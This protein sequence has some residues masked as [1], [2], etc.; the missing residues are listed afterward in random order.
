MILLM[1]TTEFYTLDANTYERMLAINAGTYGFVNVYYPNQSIPITPSEVPLLSR[2]PCCNKVL[3]DRCLPIVAVNNI[4]R[5]ESPEFDVLSVYRCASCNK[6][7]VALTHNIDTGK[8]RDDCKL[9]AIFPYGSVEQFAEEI[10]NLS[11]NFVEIYQQAEAAE[12]Y[13][14]NKVCGMGYRRAL[15]FLVTDYIM[16]KNPN[17][18]IR[19]KTLSQKINEGI[20]N[21]K[22]K[23][24]AKAASWIGNDEA[25]I[26]KKNSSK[27]IGDMKQFIRYMVAYI[28]AELTYEDA[29]AM[30][31]S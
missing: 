23:K 8:E 3:S 2:C 27:T 17:Y 16:H 25:H 10:T 29:S 30:L 7:F 1:N 28:Q 4:P 5:E 15:E 18:D 13:E 14:L 22:I 24:L 21:E 31:N 20:N 9:E 11:S 19:N 6:L 26:E 12:H